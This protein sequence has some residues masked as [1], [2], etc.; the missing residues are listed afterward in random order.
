MCN[1][2]ILTELNILLLATVE[3][4]VPTIIHDTNVISIIII[5]FS[6]VLSLIH[7]NKRLKDIKAAVIANVIKYITK[8]EREK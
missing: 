3:I 8:R 6:Q 1:I 4:I 7:P 2:N 5:G